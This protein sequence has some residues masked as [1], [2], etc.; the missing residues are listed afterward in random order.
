[1]IILVPHVDAGDRA[2]WP[3]DQDARPLSDLG[4]HQAQA[5]AT[6]LARQ[7]E[8]AALYAS[9]A[10]RAQQTLGPLAQRL[11]LPVATLDSLS[12]ERPGEDKAALAERGVQSL[13]TMRHASAGTIVAASHGDIIPATIERLATENSLRIT[14]LAHRGQWYELNIGAGGAITHVELREASDFPR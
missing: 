13:A 5:L 4:Q 12:E 1:M 9:P 7:Y 8:I 10:V 3:G 2:L 11:G 6:N 14:T